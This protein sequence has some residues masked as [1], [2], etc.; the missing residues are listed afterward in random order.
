MVFC[1]GI[2]LSHGILKE[3]EDGEL[4][5]QR[6]FLYSCVMFFII[7]LF[8][9]GGIALIASSHKTLFGLLINSPFVALICTLI[10]I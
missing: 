10:T 8:T 5:H 4:S 2:I 6:S 3:L 1:E 7:P 9:F